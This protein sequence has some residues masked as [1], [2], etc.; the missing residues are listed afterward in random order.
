MSP[1]TRKLVD[2]I[3]REY[4][5][6]LKLVYVYACRGPV[7]YLLIEVDTGAEPVV[8]WDNLGHFEALTN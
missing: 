6:D 5:R 4:T 8:V 7:P 1:A 3:N 2:E